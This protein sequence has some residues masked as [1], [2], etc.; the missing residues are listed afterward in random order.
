VS[1]LARL[2]HA[3]PPNPELDLRRSPVIRCNHSNVSVA[4]ALRRQ[5]ADTEMRL[6]G[7]ALAFARRRQPA[8][9]EERSFCPHRRVFCVRRLLTL[10]NPT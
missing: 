6:G 1:G 9:G 7:P 5:G 3:R 8:L 2:A 10:R 4:V